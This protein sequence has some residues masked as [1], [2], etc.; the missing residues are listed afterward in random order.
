MTLQLANQQKKGRRWQSEPDENGRVGNYINCTQ[1]AQ[2]YESDPGSGVYDKPVDMTLKRT[3]KGYEVSDN[4]YYFTI[5]TERG[6]E[7]G[8]I[9]FGA[10]MGKNWFRFR[11]DG[12]G[13]FDD[14]TN[15]FTNLFG[16]P[17]YSA[18]L[19]ISEF[20]RNHCKHPDL[21]DDIRTATSAIDW[22]GLWS[23]DNGGEISVRWRL[24]SDKLKQ[25]VIVDRAAREWFDGRQRAPGHWLSFRFA[26][27]IGNARVSD[28][29]DGVALLD[30]LDEL[31]AFMP[32]DYVFVKRKGGSR[33][34]RRR[35][36]QENGQ[37]YLVFGA[38]HDD[39]KGMPDGDLVFDPQ[40]T[41]EVVAGN[42][43]D[44]EVTDGANWTDTGSFLTVGQYT[45]VSDT[46][47]EFTPDVPNGA[48]FTGGGSEYATLSAYQHSTYGF[49]G[50]SVPIQVI[51]D[52]GGNAN[53]AFATSNPVD[54]NVTDSTA[55]TN[56]TI[57]ASPGAGNV[58]NSG[59]DVAAQM[60]E[61]AGQGGWSAND[62]MRFLIRDN[63]AAANNNTFIAANE[64]SVGPSA[65]DAF[66]TTGGGGG[67][68]VPTI[69][70]QMA[71]GA[72][73]LDPLAKL[74]VVKEGVKKIRNR[75]DFLKALSSVPFFGKRWF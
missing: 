3:A 74:A 1:D 62:L 56:D 6:Q 34:L 48:S 47:N 32:A 28:L 50:T 11:L 58:I 9:G 70:Q 14:V 20:K 26:V 66:Y 60:E 43:S 41:Q 7:Q 61:R 71:G 17:D 40:M 64:D 19:Q 55:V 35:F 36:Y 53:T 16:A 33:P 18:D 4:S 59:F 8:T 39:L 31:L 12:A 27:D 54:A 67:S 22:P 72:V 24:L 21:P 2:F 29:N 15:E 52:V 75:R 30:D 57:T 68:S 45:Y 23:T 42:A 69:I 49:Y 38:T 51:V 46:A 63:G 25:D 5:H 44:G 73:L 10:R 65:L 37:T 13:H